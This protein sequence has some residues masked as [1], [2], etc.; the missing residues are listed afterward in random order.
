MKKIIALT[1][2]V[3]LCLSLFG[4]GKSEAVTAF[5]GLVEEIGTVTLDSETAIVAAE[6]AYAALSDKEKEEVHDSYAS[7]TRYRFEYNEK[8][9]EEEARI[10][11]EEDQRMANE[12]IEAI[13]QL[14]TITLES[15]TAIGEA[16]ALYDALS[17]EA[18]DLV[19]N[20]DVLI[21]STTEYLTLRQNEW[22]KV[23]KENSKKFNTN[24]DAFQNITWYEH[25]SFPQYINLR[26][27]IAPVIGVQNNNVF[28]CIRYNYTGDSWVF[29]KKATI[30]VD[31]QKYVK[32]PN[33]FDITHDNNS[34][35]CEYYDEMLEVNLPMDSEPL[36]MMKAIG[37]GKEVM[38]RFEGDDYYYDYVVKDVDKK[39]FREALVLY[40]AILEKNTIFTGMPGYI[41][42]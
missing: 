40:E 27:Y 14:G 1:I 7:L 10:K 39:M 29:W 4:C 16:M 11:A 35:V 38:I 17:E 20:I 18:K 26:S 8:V 30:L 28:V 13:N 5:E 2:L 3:V 24:Y 23:I 9:A 21:A 19:T 34:D 31:G 22:D 6:N 33:Y 41:T 12:L 15:E 25:K 36:K 32:S 42:Q 37:E